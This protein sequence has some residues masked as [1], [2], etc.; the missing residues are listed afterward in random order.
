M[1]SRK[2]T[3][4]L[5]GQTVYINQDG[6]NAITIGKFIAAGIDQDT[7]TEYCVWKWQSEDI[8]DFEV[9]KLSEVFATREAAQANR[10][11]AA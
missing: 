1:L 9:C 10:E 4:F 2:Q 3:K 8:T 5:Y 11:V 7:S 6:S